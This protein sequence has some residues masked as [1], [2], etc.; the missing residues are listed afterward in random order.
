MVVGLKELETHGPSTLEKFQRKILL[1][2]EFDL[3]EK[4]QLVTCKMRL[5]EF[6]CRAKFYAE[7][8]GPWPD[9]IKKFRVE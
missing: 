6:Q 7:F 9:L 1:Y 3:S 4:P 8:L 2:L 5:A